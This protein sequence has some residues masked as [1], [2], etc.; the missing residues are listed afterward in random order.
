MRTAVVVTAL[1]AFAASP[2]LACRSSAAKA[3]G[4]HIMA[5]T[6][7]AGLCD[8]YTEA[9]KKTTDPEAAYKDV[10]DH[11]ITI[12]PPLIKM[13]AGVEGLWKGGRYP[14]WLRFARHDYNVEGWS[15][16]ALDRLLLAMIDR[17]EEKPNDK[18]HP[19]VRVAASGEVSIDGDAVPL[20]NLK[21]SLARLY[22]RDHIAHFYREGWATRM[23]PNSDAVLV[24]LVDQQ[25]TVSICAKPDCPD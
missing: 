12:W 10:Q 21:E 17:Q 11:F 25:F 5:E 16:P 7:L 13:K 6:T 19:I 8:A 20:A 1:L 3:R 18:R 15:C 2:Q 14:F 23:P 24:L 4:E 9:A 22:E